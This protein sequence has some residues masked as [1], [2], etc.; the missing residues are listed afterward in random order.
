MLAGLLPSVLSDTRRARSDRRGSVAVMAA[1]AL[2]ALAGAAGLGVDVGVWYVEAARLQTAADAAALA[3]AYLLSNTS[4]QQ[5]SAQAQAATF[6]AVA[7]AAAA[8]ATASTLIGKLATPTIKVAAD[9]SSVT[10]SMTSQASGFFSPV[11]GAAIP[12]MHATAKAGT[13]Q[14]GG[15]ACVLALDAKAAMAVHVDNMGGITASG[16]GIF[17]NSNASNAVY[18]N[19]GTISGKTVGA[20]GQ[21]STSNSGSNT[22]S[23]SPGTNYAAAQTNPLAAMTVPTPGACSYSNNPSFTAWKSTP[24]A[25]TQSQNVFCG[26]TTIGGNG[27]TDT[28]APGIYYVVNGNLTFSN[29][30]VTQAIGVTFVLTGTSPGAFSWTNYSNT[31]TQI[32][33]PTTGPTAGIV[34]WQACPSSGSAAP[35]NTMAGGSTLQISGAFY[36]PCGALNVSNNISLTSTSGGSDSV[37]ADT[38]YATGSATITANASATGSSGTV[39]QVALLQ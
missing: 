29:A 32:T 15:S 24:Y 26:N 9:W 11:I 31:A 36:A 25:F 13:L 21:V 6:L 23:P 12:T 38:I 27:T 10:V 8:D 16:C 20:V 37:V 4:L 3:S 19:S 1:L 2:P 14:H 5:Q 17:S 33:A 34:V 35:I 18:L 30:L 28:F 7:Q 39:A 22:L